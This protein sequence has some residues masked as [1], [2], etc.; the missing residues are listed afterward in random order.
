[1]NIIQKDISWL[2]ERVPDFYEFYCDHKY[3][4][5]NGGYVAG[6]FLRKIIHHGSCE[7]VLAQMT[8][9]NITGDVDWFFRYQEGCKEAWNS[10]KPMGEAADYPNMLKDINE[11]NSQTKFAFEGFNKKTRIKYQFIYKSYGKPETTLGCFD[12]S[13][14]KI[15]TDG[16]TVWM[17]E[18]WEELES[19][20]FIRVD[21][22]GGDYLISRLK[23][24]VK[25]GFDVLPSQAEEVICK[26]LEAS[27]KYS[28]HVRCLMQANFMQGSDIL[29]F[30]NKLG[31]IS[32]DKNH[33]Y[34]RCSI[35]V[36]EDFAMHM[37][38]AKTKE[39]EHSAF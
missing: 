27:T 7:F 34:N 2:V 23:K 16:W 9:R 14:C 38:K 37:Y 24:Y 32:A 35:A 3:A 28:F 39:H 36:A 19:N 15:A 5:N 6:G 4:F 1:M 26:M 11:P 30:Y 20:K 18:D 31:E 22:F 17:V 21:N 10:F 12:I 29:L 13:N 25:D 33:D 8:K